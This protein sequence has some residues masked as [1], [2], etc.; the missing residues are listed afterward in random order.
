M[1]KLGKAMIKDRN[2]VQATAYGEKNKQIANEMNKKYNVGY[3]IGKVK[4]VVSFY[5]GKKYKDNSDFYDIKT[6]SNKKK[7]KKF[8]NEL[9][10]KGYK[11]N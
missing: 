10:S 9:V 4:Y 6:F 1:S 8:E 7:L 3:N 2:V 11:R 5:S